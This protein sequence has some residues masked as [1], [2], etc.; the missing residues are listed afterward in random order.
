MIEISWKQ[1]LDNYTEELKG[2]NLWKYYKR[3]LYMYQILCIVYCIHL[4]GGII[5]LNIKDIWDNETRYTIV[6][7]V[8]Y[9][10]LLVSS[11]LSMNVL[12]D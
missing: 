8:C 9:D 2:Y 1:Y 10:E 12:I 3:I 11:S 7:F 4:G 6:N 5:R